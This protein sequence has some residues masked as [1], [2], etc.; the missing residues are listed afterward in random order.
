M[1]ICNHAVVSTTWK[2]IQTFGRMVLSVLIHKTV[3]ILWLLIRIKW[4]K[5]VIVTSLKCI[6]QSITFRLKFGSK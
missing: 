1:W 6:I 5:F 3:S 2:F 4:I